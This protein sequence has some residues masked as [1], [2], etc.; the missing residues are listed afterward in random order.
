MHSMFIF[1]ISHFRIH[2]G[3]HKLLEKFN[4]IMHAL[5]GWQ[6]GLCHT[7]RDV[8]VDFRHAFGKCIH[9]FFFPTNW[10]QLIEVFLQPLEKIPLNF[11]KASSLFPV[12]DNILPLAR[13]TLLSCVGRAFLSYRRTWV[14]ELAVMLQ[15][16]R[17][18]SSYTFRLSSQHPSCLLL[19]LLLSFQNLAFKGENIL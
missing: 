13:P 4:S 9:F 7:V 12:A 10:K 2:C 14:K 11:D 5:G 17:R 1:A 15:Q 6:K 19:C 16:Q 8:F 3:N 18:K